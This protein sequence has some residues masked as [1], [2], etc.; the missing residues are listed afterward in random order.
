MPAQF[1][2]FMDDNNPDLHHELGDEEMQDFLI[3]RDGNEGVLYHTEMTKIKIVYNIHTGEVRFLDTEQ[4]P[5]INFDYTDAFQTQRKL[6]ELAIRRLVKLELLA[7][8]NK[9]QDEGISEIIIQNHAID[10]DTGK[11]HSNT[12]E[13][14]L[15]MTLVKIVK[16]GYL[17]RGTGFSWR[18][19][20]SGFKN[21]HQT[22]MQKAVYAAFDDFKKHAGHDSRVL[23]KFNSK[24][25]MHQFIDM[26][27]KHL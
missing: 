21:Q 2:V 18:R 10:R 3:Q 4:K 5:D 20:F 6:V 7:E 9:L 27:K 17:D 22:S 25:A 12:S 16:L 11:I 1:Y 24:Q 14:M 19:L 26:I 23:E 15:D 8:L 13:I